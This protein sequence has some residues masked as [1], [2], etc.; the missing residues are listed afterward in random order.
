LQLSNQHKALLITAFI[1]GTVVFAVLGLNLKQQAQVIAE[2]Y[3]ELTPETPPQEELIR[4]ETTASQ[5]AQ[6]SAETNKAFNATKK[7]THFAQ[8]FKPIAPPKEYIPSKNFDDT[9]T[10]DA[11]KSKYKNTHLETSTPESSAAY[12]KVNALLKKQQSE[13]NTANSSMSFSLIN[14]SIMHYD[15]PIY[16]CENGGKVIITITVNPNGNVVDAYFN[17]SS[18]SSNAC[19][20]NHAIQYAKNVKFNTATVAKGNQVGSITFIFMGK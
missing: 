5:Q 6:R 2:S 18:S 20:V 3:Y 19:L 12:D 11:L 8:A 13:G 16:L 17:S 14:R 15:T 9:S 10:L 4:S 7:S 1:A